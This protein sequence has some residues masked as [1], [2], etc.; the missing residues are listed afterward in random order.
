MRH[1]M[2]LD[3]PALVILDVLLPDADGLELLKEL[4]A[5]PDGSSLP[6][7]LLS[8][9][10]EVK[11]RIKGLQTGADDYVG[12]PYDVNYVVA[13]ARELLHQR[14]PA[15]G[16]PVPTILVID[17]SATSTRFSLPRAVMKACGSPPPPNQ[18]RSSWMA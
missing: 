16:S 10:A 4:R 3:Q 17:D 8:S 6:V 2:M 12:K 13:R 9:E 14:Q 15:A 11:S 5:R 1:R 18:T 7:L